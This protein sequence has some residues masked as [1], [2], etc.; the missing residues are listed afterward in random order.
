M[1][2]RLF[3]WLVQQ[4][5]L[6]QSPLRATPR[7]ETAQRLSYLSD[8]EQARQLLALAETLPDRSTAPLRGPTYRTIFALLYGLGLRVADGAGDC[9]SR[10]GPTSERTFLDQHDPG[11]YSGRRVTD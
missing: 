10:N 3:T 1:L 9:Y 8:A 6:T 7:R 2:R 4:R 11:Q 5:E